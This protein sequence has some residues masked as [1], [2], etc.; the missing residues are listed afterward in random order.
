MA[1][2]GWRPPGREGGSHHVLRWVMLLWLIAYPVVSCAPALIGHEGNVAT[3]TVGA[4]ASLALGAALLV[5][6]ILGIVV[7]GVLLAVTRPAPAS[8]EFRDPRSSVPAPPSPPSAGTKQCPRC[9]AL[10][11]AAV[12]SC[13]SCGW[14]PSQPI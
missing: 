13:W 8:V 10:V 4:I 3:G 2:P 1:D 7:L 6:W 9:G 14:D 12:P 5:P 11:H